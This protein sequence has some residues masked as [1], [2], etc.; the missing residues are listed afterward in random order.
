MSTASAC[1]NPPITRVVSP[2]LR[3]PAELVA[4]GSDGVGAPSAKAVCTAPTRRSPAKLNG[5]MGVF[6]E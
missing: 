5:L 3:G 1:R 6:T 2:A 4:D